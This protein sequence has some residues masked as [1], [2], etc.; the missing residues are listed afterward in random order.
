MREIEN[1]VVFTQPPRKAAPISGVHLQ[2]Q[3][4]KPLTSNTQV[5]NAA[6]RGLDKPAKAFSVYSDSKRTMEARIASNASVTARRALAPKCSLEGDVSCRTVK[7]TRHVPTSSKPMPTDADMSA[8]IERM[9]ERK[10]TEIMANRDREQ[11]APTGGSEISEDVRRRL[12]ELERKVEQGGPDPKAEGLRFLLMAKQHKERGEDASALKMYELA[13]PFFPGQEKLVRKMENL[14]VKL[15]AKREQAHWSTERVWP[16][17]STDRTGLLPA[18]VHTSSL[19]KKRKGH[20][21]SEDDFEVERSYIDEDSL[22]Y[23]ARQSKRSRSKAA[24]RANKHDS[25]APH[26]DAEPISPRTVHLLGIINSRDVAQIR[27]LSGVGPAKAKII[28]EFLEL[29]DDAESTRILSLAQLRD[30]PG[31]GSKTLDR[32][33][34]GIRIF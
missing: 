16:T 30:V 3:P 27:G 15:Q 11:P 2:R 33:R 32:A 20:D 34:E 17:T 8:T 9:V 26:M 12:E 22:E 18:A 5:H 21:E 31:M 4:L 13:L 19:A 24:G 23:D 7:A 29:Q 6:Q 28:V 1:E 10:V 14:R 25:H